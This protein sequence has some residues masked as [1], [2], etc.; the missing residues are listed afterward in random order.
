MKHIQ[1]YHI[2]EAKGPC[3]SGYKQIGTKMKGG[4]RVPRCVPVKET[5]MPVQ[6]PAGWTERDNSLYKRYDFKDFNVAMSFMNE[7]AEVCNRMNHHPKWTNIFK[8]VQCWLRT[9][10]AGDVI[11]ERDYKLAQAMD[12]IASKHH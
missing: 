3:W 2:D 10:D 11:T 12:R 9:H 5:E 4:R 1:P 8:T 6:A 7:V